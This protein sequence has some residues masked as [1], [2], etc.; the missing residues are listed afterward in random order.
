MKILQVNTFINSRSTGR[1]AEDIGNLVIKQGWGSFYA[2]GR[3]P[4]SSNSEAIQI[5]I[6]IDVLLHGFQSILLDDHGFG[7][8]HATKVFIEKVKIL[9]PDVIHLHNIHGYYLNIELLFNYLKESNTPV[10]WTLHDCW[11]FTGHCAYYSYIDCGKWKTECNNCPQLSSYPRSIFKDKSK[12]NFYSKMKLFNS[13]ENLTI[14]PVSNW[15]KKELEMSFLKNNKI[16][17]IHNG[18]DLNVFRP[19]FKCEIFKD[20]NLTSKFV[21]LGVANVWEKRKGL[22][23]FMKLSKLLSND[24]VIFLV[25][26]NHKQLKGLPDNIIGISKT[27]NITELAEIYSNADVLFNPTWEDNFPTVNL[28]SLACGTPV[29]TYNTGGSIESVDAK[30]GFVI[31]QGDVSAAIERI[32]EIKNTLSSIYQKNCREKAVQFYDKDVVFQ[33]YIEMYNELRKGIK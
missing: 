26:L 16:E 5:G 19:S 33:D 21:I 29:V 13:L 8:K 14:V 17:V 4:K 18:V 9:K 27:E 1:I 12:I 31:E 32:R 10:V 20:L 30:T 24:E 22:E 11:S 15:L 25:G 28:E 23:D 2:F 6:K 3:E 7:S